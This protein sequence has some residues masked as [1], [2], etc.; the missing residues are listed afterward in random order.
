VVATI[1][2]EEMERP[3]AD[4]VAMV[5]TARAGVQVAERNKIRARGC[6]AILAQLL[7][8][9]PETGAA[10]L[11]AAWKDASEKAAGDGLTPAQQLSVTEAYRAVLVAAKPTKESERALVLDLIRTNLRLRDLAE[12]AGDPQASY[13][14]WLDALDVA[15]VKLRDRAEAELVIGR[16]PTAGELAGDLASRWEKL[17]ELLKGL[18]AAG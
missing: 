5:G 2:S 10:D 14:Y 3:G 12:K 7:A 18:P 1:L 16:R 15:V 4:V 13:R 11:R 8:K 6:R 17:Q 9:Q